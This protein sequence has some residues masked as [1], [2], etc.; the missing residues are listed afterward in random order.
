MVVLANGRERGMVKLLPRGGLLLGKAKMFS[1]CRHGAGGFE[2]KTIGT[3][4]GPLPAPPGGWE[5]H[6]KGHRFVR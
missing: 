1:R 4:T 3:F 5:S 2:V 6:F